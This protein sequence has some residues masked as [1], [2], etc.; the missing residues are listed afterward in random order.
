MKTAIERYNEILKDNDELPLLITMLADE[1][2]LIT[3]VKRAASG[4]FCWV[5]RPIDN[6]FFFVKE[7]QASQFNQTY[8]TKKINT[9]LFLL[10]GMVELAIENKAR[11]KQSIIRA[12]RNKEYR[13]LAQSIND[14]I[15]FAFD[16]ERMKQDGIEV[17]Q[18]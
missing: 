4:K 8:G 14:E 5:Y 13:E 15:G 11:V 17:I 2:K 12:I 18:L 6:G 1:N 7:K 9:D 10:V 16:I 3:Y